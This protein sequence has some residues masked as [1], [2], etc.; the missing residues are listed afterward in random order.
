MLLLLLVGISAFALF[1]L[2]HLNKINNILL[3]TDLPIVKISVKMI[4]VILAQEWHVQ[5]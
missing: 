5:R 3:E 1:Y 2:N 4:D